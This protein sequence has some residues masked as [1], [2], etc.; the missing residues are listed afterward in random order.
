MT[1]LS[2]GVMILL[3]T[4]HAFLSFGSNIGHR[5][6]HHGTRSHDQELARSTQSGL[7]PFT[8]QCVGNRTEGF[9]FVI[10]RGTWFRTVWRTSMTDSQLL[11]AT[12]SDRGNGSTR[13]KHRLCIDTVYSDA[14]HSATHRSRAGF[15]RSNG[16]QKNWASIFCAHLP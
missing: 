11:A 1:I 3:A 7:V 15:P 12:H 10:N 14:L 9:S 2:E 16:M 5:H 6:I 13:F 8:F 4:S